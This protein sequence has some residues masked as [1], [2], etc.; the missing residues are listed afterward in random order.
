MKTGTMGIMAGSRLNNILDKMVGSLA[1]RIFIA[2]LQTVLTSV[3]LLL[4]LLIAIMVG[5][6]AG[7]SSRRF[8]KGHTQF[9][10]LLTAILSAALSLILL[11]SLS[12]GFL[13]I[14]LFNQMVKKPDWASLIQ[15]GIAALMCS[16]S[17]GQTATTSA[18]S[19]DGFLSSSSPILELFL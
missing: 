6:I 1:G 12:G 4:A 11:N 5:A 13:G 7:F 9:L 16:D 8:L 19:T 18:N 10:K 17:C 15:F 14:N 2:F 3:V